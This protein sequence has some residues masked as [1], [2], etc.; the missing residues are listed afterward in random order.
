M[1]KSPKQQ[2]QKEN[3]KNVSCGKTTTLEKNRETIKKSINW[4]TASVEKKTLKI[5][6]I[7]AGVEKFIL[8]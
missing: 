7:I 4:K 6:K 8:F 2:I 3:K 1:K 5:E